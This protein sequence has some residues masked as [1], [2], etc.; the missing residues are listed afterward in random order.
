MKLASTTQLIRYDFPRLFL[1]PLNRQDKLKQNYRVNDTQYALLLADKQVVDCQT[2]KL[3]QFR[4][5][6]DVGLTVC[7]FTNWLTSRNPDALRR[8]AAANIDFAISHGRVRPRRAGC[9]RARA[10]AGE[11]AAFTE[12]VPFRVPTDYGVQS[13]RPVSLA[14]VGNKSPSEPSTRSTNKH[15]RPGRRRGRCEKRTE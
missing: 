10:G 5:T 6:S 2:A 14:P 15:L 1:S 4:A 11:P 7:L 8:Q 9:G 12:A 3:A 13:R